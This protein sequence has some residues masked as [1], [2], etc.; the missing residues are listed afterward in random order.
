MPLHYPTPLE[1]VTR[2]PARNS[3]IWLHGLGANGYDFLPIVDELGPASL[4]PTRFIFPHAPEQAVTWNGGLVMPSW[5]DI[6]GLHAAAAEDEAGLRASMHYLDSLIAREIER[7]IA[8]QHIVL[9]GFSQGATMAL[10]TALRYPQALAGV[11]VLSGYLPLAASFATEA[12]PANAP[13]PIFLAHGTSDNVVPLRLGENTRVILERNKYVV[14]WRTYPISHSVC[15]QEIDD[16]AKFL[17]ARLAA[18]QA[19]L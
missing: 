12:H 6:I 9:A 11:V 19:E 1:V 10:H 5:Y 17:S 18:K 2:E 16:I 13:T 14:T 7:G 15:T 3:V 4:A 8:P